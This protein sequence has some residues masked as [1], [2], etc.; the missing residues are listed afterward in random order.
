M[1]TEPQRGS[2]DS[3][4][5][6]AMKIREITVCLDVMEEPL[7]RPS[8]HGVHQPICGHHSSLGDMQ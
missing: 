2:G 3:T 4:D 7:V 5:N 8:H 6:M 1:A